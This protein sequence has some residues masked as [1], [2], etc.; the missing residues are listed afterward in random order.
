MLQY[1]RFVFNPIQV[2]TWVIYESSGDCLIIDPGCYDDSEQRELSRFIDEEGLTPLA[3]I[4]THG[5]FDHI[6]GVHYVMN[7]YDCLFLGNEKDQ[8]L[9]NYA[10]KQGSMFGFNID[11]SPLILDRLLTDGEELR[12][13]SVAL[14]VFHVPGHS[15][16]SL[17]LYSSESKFVVV[18]DVLFKG[19][20]G[21]TDLPGGDTL[22]LI[23]SIKEKLMVLPEDTIV[24]P[25][26]GL[27]TNIGIEKATNP[28][29]V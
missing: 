16:G 24:M 2:N 5:H 22:T 26:H 19:S 8:E 15:A 6:T 4:A 13:G 21:R 9:I 11:D 20:I 27:E 12:I 7:R 14:K 28:F 3:V 23:K 29:L 17:A 25:G 18:G 1:K 10:S